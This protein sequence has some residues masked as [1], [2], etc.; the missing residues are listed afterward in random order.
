MLRKLYRAVSIS[1]DYLRYRYFHSE[2][3]VKKSFTPKKYFIA[4]GIGDHEECERL[5]NDL[6]PKR[7]HVK[8]DDADLVC[9]HFFDFWAAARLRRR[10][11]TIYG[12]AQK[13]THQPHSTSPLI[14]MRTLKA[15][16]SGIA[17]HSAGLSV[18]ARKGELKSKYPGSCLDSITSLQ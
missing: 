11:I 1:Y 12:G 15:D 18:S 13:K 10:L 17:I 16:T 14:G 3:A 7:A 8:S 6:F 5:F 9:N 4:D 2:P